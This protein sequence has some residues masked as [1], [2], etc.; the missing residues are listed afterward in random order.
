[1]WFT[2]TPWP[3]IIILCVIGVLLFLGWL[4]QRRTGYLAGVALCV[5]LSGF[6]W[7]LE[8]QIVTEREQVEQRLLDFAAT[9]QRESLQRGPVNLLLGGPEPQTFAFISA[10]AKEVK[11]LALQALDLVD[12]QE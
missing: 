7:V 11:D 8:R 4:S 9:F 6:V 12:I 2:E 10:S 3:P 5:A 1:M